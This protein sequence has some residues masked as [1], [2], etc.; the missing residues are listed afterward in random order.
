VKSPE[1]IKIENQTIYVASSELMPQ[2]GNQTVD[3]I[4]TSPPYNIGKSYKRGSTKYDDQKPHEEYL[5]FLQHVFKE[6]YRVLKED[7]VFFLNIGDS[8]RDQG[9]SE[10]VVRRAVEVGFT[11][12]QSI[13]WVKSIFGKGHY[14]PSGKNRRLNNLWEF[15]YVLVKD[16]KYRYEPRTLGIPYV[17]KSN[18]GRYS[19]EDLRDAGD[20]WFIPYAITTGATV[21][22]GHQ[23]PYPVELPYRCIRLV[24]QTHLVLDPFVGSGSTLAAARSLGIDGVGYEPL[25]NKDVI[26][27]RILLDYHP[28]VSPLLPQL[29]I[30][31]KI[32]TRLG[33]EAKPQ[34]NPEVVQ[35]FFESLSAR[36]LKL[37]KWACQDLGYDDTIPH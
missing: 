7:G 18:I 29:E 3:V 9:K 21:K 19:D 35:K 28:P 8:A 12:L 15:V 2:L 16:Q 17:D 33:G 6:C 27:N 32:L 30:Y 5:E 23:A 13:I 37:F 20:V 36:E 4:V 26:R 34:L 10:D 1:T 22:K 11:R 24:P 31:A 14:T 25:P